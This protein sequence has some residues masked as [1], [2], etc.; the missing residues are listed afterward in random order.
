V[1]SRHQPA[2]TPEKE[3]A[4]RPRTEENAGDRARL[5]KRPDARLSQEVALSDLRNASGG[6]EALVKGLED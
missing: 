6:F 1:H 2:L 4:S 5:V 3:K